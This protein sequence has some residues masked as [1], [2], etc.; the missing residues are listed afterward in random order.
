MF[1][2]KVSPEVVALKATIQI[3]QEIEN[4]PGFA[5]YEGTKEDF[6]NLYRPLFAIANE[7][8]SAECPD[9]LG[10]I[11]ETFYQYECEIAAGERD[12]DWYLY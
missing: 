8:V 12:I 10:Q 9:Y 7:E 1:H 11:I 5:G 3:H 4:D 2:D 6:D